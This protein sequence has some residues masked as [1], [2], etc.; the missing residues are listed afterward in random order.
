[1]I[2]PLTEYLD[3]EIIIG[4][5]KRYTEDKVPTGSF[6]RAVLENNLVEAIGRADYININRLPSIVQYI[7]ENLPH[8]CWG[9]AEIVNNFL[10]S[11]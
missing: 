5:L 11:K 2:K 10:K 6:L 3:A 9:S 4:S 8:N 1:M 7:Y